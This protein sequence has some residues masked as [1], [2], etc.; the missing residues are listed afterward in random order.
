MQAA[1][2]GPRGRMPREAI[3]VPAMS[4]VHM[5]NQGPKDSSSLIPCWP[6]MGPHRPL[7]VRETILL[8]QSQART[9]RRGP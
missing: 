9:W 6:I 8:G 1:G 7:R 5:S 2:M 4:L 3:S